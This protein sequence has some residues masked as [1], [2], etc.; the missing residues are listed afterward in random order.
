MKENMSLL[1]AAFMPWNSK[2]LAALLAVCFMA[3]QTTRAQTVGSFDLSFDAPVVSGT[4][5]WDFA[6]PCIAAQ[7][8]RKIIIAGHFT[9]VNGEAHTNIARLLVNGELDPS[10]KADTDLTGSIYTL[11]IQSDGKILIGGV[12]TT[13]NGQPRNNLARLPHGICEAALRSA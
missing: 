5:D 9:S 4:P 10:F 7:P 12:F 13:V 11:A 6:I 8:D 2:R 3:G 1:S